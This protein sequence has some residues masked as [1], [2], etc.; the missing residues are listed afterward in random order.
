MN[1][2]YYPVVYKMTGDTGYTGT[3]AD[4]TINAIAAA[5]AGKFGTA[6]TSTDANN[7]TTYTVTSAVIAP[8]TD[9]DDQFEVDDEVITWAWAFGGNYTGDNATENDKADT[10]LGLLM[11]RHVAG[12]DTLDGTVVMKSASAETYAAPTEHTDFC[13]DTSFDLNITVNQVD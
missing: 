13:L 11:A 5:I 1:N 9:L 12:T 7:I 3:D 8:N 2:N 6:T 4:D 10:I